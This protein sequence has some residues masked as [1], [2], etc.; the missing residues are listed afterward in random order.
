MKL[1]LW[2]G[3]AVG[4][5]S[6]GSTGSAATIRVPAEVSSIELAVGL[7]VAGDTVLIAPGTY[8]DTG[9]VLKGGLTLRG[10]GDG[11]VIYGNEDGDAGTCLIAHAQSQEIR[12]ERL[13]LTGGSGEINWGAAI[14]A[15]DAQLRI[16]DCVLRGNSSWGEYEGTLR[17]RDSSIQ[18]FG[19][20]FQY[21]G[22]YKNEFSFG[23]SICAFDSDFQVEGTQFVDNHTYL[24]SD[25]HS[26]RTTWAFT[27]CLFAGGDHNSTLLHF[28]D[29]TVSM[30]RCTLRDNEGLDLA[31]AYS[32]AF[33]ARDCLFDSDGPENGSASRGGIAVGSG[34]E[35]E[36]VN[37]TLSYE[38]VTD[39]DWCALRVGGSVTLRRSIVLVSS[40]NRAARCWDG[41]LLTIRCTNL[42]AQGNDLLVDCESHHLDVQAVFR[43]DPQFCGVPGSGDYFLQSDSPCSPEHNLCG[44]LIGA[45][46]VGCELTATSPTSFSAIKSLY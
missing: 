2:I 30:E 34:I 42:Y 17:A 8:H 21:N 10:E 37:C 32:G 9:I 39:W 6:C 38:S 33:F 24:G 12:L 7:A 45:Y 3:I 23:T 25:I 43:S 35:A 4:M 36:F 29:C 16:E 1:R 20:R 41:S 18:L 13:E 14:D 31:L 11:V 28:E 5:S 44:E 27:D 26:E 46:P 40:G 19:C 15:R 22:H